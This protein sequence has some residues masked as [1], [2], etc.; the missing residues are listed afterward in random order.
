MAEGPLILD[1]IAATTAVALCLTISEA[2]LLTDNLSSF[3]GVLA[4]DPRSSD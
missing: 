3:D 1:E 4:F 2:D